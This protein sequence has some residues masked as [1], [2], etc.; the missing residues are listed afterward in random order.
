MDKKQMA[1][2]MAAFRERLAAIQDAYETLDAN[3]HAALL[4]QHDLESE[5][6]Y[7]KEQLQHLTVKL[8]EIDTENEN[9]GTRP[10]R[11][12]QNLANIYEDGFHICNL[13]YGQRRNPNEQCMFCLDILASKRKREE[14]HD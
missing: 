13:S 4:K 2:D 8:L 9:H 11:A 12:M 1:L 3:W 6:A 10:S 14:G 7:L 5:N